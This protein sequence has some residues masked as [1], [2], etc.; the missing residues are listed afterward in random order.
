M[1]FKYLRIIVLLMLLSNVSSAAIYQVGSSKLYASPN[2]LYQAGVVQDG[3]TIEI[4]AETYSGTESLAVWQ[5]N[6][7]LIKGVGGRP[8]LEADGQYIWGKGIWV[9]VGNNNTVENIEFSGASVPHMNGAGIRLDGVGLTVRHCFFH[10][11]ENGILTSNPYDGEILIEFSE[12]A[13]NGYG[14][15]F[16]HNVYVGHVNKLTFKFN[17][18]HHAYIGHNLKSRAQENYIICNR[19]MDEEEG[20]SSR[21]ID[22]SNGGF[23]IVMGNLFMQGNNAENNNLIG[24]GKEGL[25]NL[26]NYLY[27]TNNTLVNKRTASCIFMD[28]ADGTPIAMISNNIFAGTGTTI[29]GETSLFVHNIIEEEID[30]LHFVDENNYDYNLLSNSPAIDS[31]TAQPTIN[32]Y[33][34]N[35]DSI[36]I[37]PTG[38]GLRIVEGEFDVGA[39]E[40][41]TPNIISD[42]HTQEIAIYPNPFTD[43]FSIDEMLLE[44]S[45]VKLFNLEGEDLGH[46]IHIH[47]NDANTIVDTSNLPIGYYILKIDSR[48]QIIYKH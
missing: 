36:Y 29:N 22:L 9:L 31:G 6:D 25:S 14:D 13:N 44:P 18:S 24:Y 42:N 43:M 40:Y 23:S 38:F 1:T 19:I 27:F 30:N 20:Q 47:Q 46:L 32:N 3:D 15:G 28:I 35:S 2:A 37:H 34:L 5:S 45:D 4:D 33:S 8:H 10:D 7:L 12:F 21:L 11:N 41:N 39:Y 17:Y 16:S 26:T 48:I